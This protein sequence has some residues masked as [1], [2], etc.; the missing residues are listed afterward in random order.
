[1]SSP[2]LWMNSWLGIQTSNWTFNTSCYIRYMHGDIF[3]IKEMS[4]KS[5]TCVG[6]FLTLKVLNFWKF[7]K[8]WNGHISDS[9]LSLRPLWLGMEEVV[10]ARTSPTLHPPSI[11]HLVKGRDLLHQSSVERMKFSLA[12]IRTFGIHSFLWLQKKW[13]Q[14]AACNTGSQLIYW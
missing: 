9:Y 6:T 5:W 1:M 10:P 7:T 4:S 13:W 14:Q 3:K 11:V 2:F 12:S 8:K